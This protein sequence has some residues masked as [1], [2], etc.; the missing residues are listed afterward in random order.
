MKFAVAKYNVLEKKFQGFSF[1]HDTLESAK[2][3]A[4][5][6]TDKQPE[7]LFYV[8]KIIGHYHIHK[9]PA[10]WKGGIDEGRKNSL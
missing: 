8:I 10:I 6:L 9:S 2:T 1:L 4:K 7:D 5:R 3:E